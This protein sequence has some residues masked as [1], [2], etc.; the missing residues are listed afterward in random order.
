MNEGVQDLNEPAIGQKPS[1][2][3][4]SMRSANVPTVDARYWSAITLAS[5]FGCNLG[6]CLSFYAHWN[7]WIGLAPL[8]AIFALLVGGERRSTRATQAWYWTV[9]IVLRAAATNLADLATHTFEWPYVRVILGLTV[10]QILV[11]WPVLPRSLLPEGDPTNR[12][13]TTGWYWLSLLTAGT[14]GTAI[15]DWSADA[16]HLGTGYAT[17]ALGA[18]FAVVL[19]IGRESRWTTKSAFWS[20]IVAVRAAGTTAGDWMAFREEPGLS[21]GL[22]LGL[23]L[24]TALNCA[25][26]VGILLLW[27]RHLGSR[28]FAD[29]GD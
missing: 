8:A 16:L 21:N 11:I 7:H 10:L 26:F 2:L 1:S 15:G 27:K 29:S 18:I 13:A 5:I 3:V 24:S 20:A 23:P 22:N 17:I 19:L 9:V 6:D 28:K 4:Q 14:L 25:L 12:P